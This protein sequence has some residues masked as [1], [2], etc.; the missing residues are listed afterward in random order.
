[1]EAT[2]VLEQL[3]QD[4]DAGKGLD[5]AA[6]KKLTEAV[7]ALPVAPALV[8]S[9]LVVSDISAEYESRFLPETAEALKTAFKKV[10]GPVEPEYKTLFLSVV[11]KKP[12]HI[13]AA[14]DALI[15][16]VEKLEFVGALMGHLAKLSTIKLANDYG[17]AVFIFPTVKFH[18]DAESYGDLF[19]LRFHTL[20]GA[21]GQ[22][23]EPPA[24]ATPPPAI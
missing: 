16:E 20:E 23:F 1:M 8:E 19:D 14:A 3:S 10:I 15:D 5:F 24:A 22:V 18:F 13:P 9:A 17:T 6:L 4:L 7:E 2:K 11:V 21:V 12:E